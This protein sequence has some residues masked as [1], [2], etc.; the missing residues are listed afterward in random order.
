MNQTMIRCTQCGQPFTANVRTVVD[1]QSDPQGKALIMNGRLNMAQCPHCGHVNRIVAPVL[2]HDAQ[3]QLLIAHV[4]GEILGGGQTEEKV[5]G[6]L[7]NELTRALPKD[8]FKAYMFNPKRTLTPQGMIDLIMQADGITPEMMDAQKKRVELLQQFISAPTAEDL[9]KL[10]EDNDSQID[11]A[12]FQTMRL[13]AQRLVAEG[14]QDI[15]SRIVIL[16]DALLEKSTF[17]HEIAL[18]QEA[19]AGVVQ[20]VAEAIQNLG[21]NATRHDFI[22]LALSYADDDQR[23]QALVGLVRPA[24]DEQLMQELTEL[25]A[26]ASDDDRPKLEQLFERITE[27]TDNIDAQVQTQVAQTAQFLQMLIN[28]PDPDAMIEANLDLIDDDFMA[29]LSANLQDAQR[30]GDANSFQRL[31]IIYQKVVEMLRSQMSPELRFLNELLAVA[32]DHAA[33]HELLDAN[34]DALGPALA[35]AAAAVEQV[36]QAQGQTEALRRLTI[37]RQHLS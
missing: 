12:F 6:D 7:L 3:H 4:P 13:M 36:L 18:Q 37:I 25:V 19:Q 32:D 9:F 29:I 15:A 16:Q 1:V 8:Q 14:R 21:Q 5:V 10:I 2:Y 27:L 11:S 31:N 26:Q 34:K 23:L 24:F 35:E 20:S 33:L 17:G 30:R 28:S 22:Q